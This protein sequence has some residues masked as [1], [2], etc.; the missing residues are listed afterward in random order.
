MPSRKKQSSGL[1][2]GMV[3]IGLGFLV[4]PVQAQNTSRTST[5]EPA[6][7]SGQTGN[8]NR[9]PS[10]GVR[11]PGG[12]VRAPGG[13]VRAPGGGVRGPGTPGVIRDEPRT[14]TFTGTGTGVVLTSGFN[15]GFYYPGYGYGWGWGRW[16]GWGFRQI[17]DRYLG[18]VDGPQN[19]RLQGGDPEP[20]P[21]TPIESARAWMAAGNPDEA[22]GW[23]REY[24]DENPDDAR[25][26]REYAAA[27][28]EGGRMLDAVALMGYAYS[29]E[30]GMVNEAM[31]PLIWGGS[32]FRLRDAVTD[33]VRYGHRVSSGNVWLLVAVLMQAEG[34]DMVALKMIN[35][36]VDEGLDQALADRMRL[37]LSQ[38]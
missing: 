8:P 5:A 16:Y 15:G 11:A 4:S 6:N 14:I 32:A 18:T 37:R 24:L 28:L 1:T 21:M 29:Q 26:M 20:E 35:R 38:R 22:A 9:A 25:V 36:A 33:S 3:V 12:G 23:Y 34:R 13:G 17:P 7:T 31:S 2:A 19:Q 27:L 10:G 30:P